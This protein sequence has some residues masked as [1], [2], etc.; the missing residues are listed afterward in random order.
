MSSKNFRTY[1]LA[2]TANQEMT[3]R[4]RGNM[5]A[6]IDNVGEFTITFDESSRIA[7]ATS[8]TGGEFDDV[9]ENI[10]LLS[11]TTQ[12]VVIILGFGKYRD[13]RA[14]LNATINTT[15]APTNTLSAIAE[16]TV[17]VVATL[18]AAANVDRKELR[19]AI[20]SVEASGV[21]FGPATVTAG[22]GGYLEEG[23]VDYINTEAAVYAI[24]ASSTVVVNVLELE[25]P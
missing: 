8:G 23:M 17:G 19:L 11:T 20:K 25:R 4:V 2:L 1:N 7:K 10:T 15:I 9:Y 18:L 6:V 13:A 12:S 22:S 5:Y 14:T 3:L 16:V 24:V 21:Y